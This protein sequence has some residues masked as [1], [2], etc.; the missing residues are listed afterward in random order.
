MS[1]FAEFFDEMGVPTLMEHLGSPVVYVAA[2]GVRTPLTALAVAVATT[3]EREQG[4][5]RRMVSGV[6]ISTDPESPEGGIADPKIT[7]SVEIDGVRYAIEAIEARSESTA[8]LKLH[9][10]QTIEHGRPNYRG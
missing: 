2:E 3:E 5:T 7:A 4:R 9:R 8:F 1:S 6:L 10:T